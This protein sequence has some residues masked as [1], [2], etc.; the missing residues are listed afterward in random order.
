MVSPADGKY[1]VDSCIKYEYESSDSTMSA[2]GNL[3]CWH[4]DA[5]QQ[6]KMQVLR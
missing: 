4:A 6:N 2:T 5:I 3:S 1:N